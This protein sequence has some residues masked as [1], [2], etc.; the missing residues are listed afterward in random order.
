M[1]ASQIPVNFPIP[2]ANSAG[3]S[4]IRA[5]PQASQISITPGA[6]SLT[7]GFPPLNFIDPTL[8]GVPP[9]G[10]DMNGIL[11]EITAN[12]RWIQ[13]GGD[14]YYNATFAL[15]I[16]G[17]PANGLIRSADSSSWW[18][19]LADNNQTNPDAGPAVFTGSISATTLT[20][21]AITSGVLVQ[22]QI[23]SGAGVTTGTVIL[24]Q[25]TGTAGSTG[26]YTVSAS[27]T[28]TSTTITATGAANWIAN[29]INA[30]QA[31]GYINRIRNSGF[32]IAQVNGNN[33]VTVTAGDGTTLAQWQSFA[34]VQIDGFYILCTGANVTGQRV[35]G[36]AQD[37]YK[38]QITGAASVTGISFG[39]R[40][41]SDNSYDLN[42]TTCTLSVEL[43]NSLLTTVTWTA[44]YANTTDTFGYVGAYTR[45]Q[46]AT[47][48]FTVSGTAATYS[49]PIAIPAAATT[50]I[51]IVFSVGAQTS[52]TWTIGELQ[53][54]QGTVPTPFEWAKPEDQLRWCQRY[55][56]VLNSGSINSTIGPAYSN[57]TVLA[58]GIVQ[59]PTA[60]RIAP[61][62][63]VSTAASQFTFQSAGL[64]AGSAIAFI[65]AS[66]TVGEV[67]LTIA[68]AI[69]GQ[70]GRMYF[71]NASAQLYFT[72]AQL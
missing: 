15:G 18:R 54:E 67:T 48:T 66:T 2:F 58:V 65:A 4:Y 7:D 60:T 38:Y 16:G 50:G 31:G 22:G 55:L 64:F 41:T 40:I 63:I 46:I 35:A 1:L 49:T 39:Q 3:G 21:T 36:A 43:A 8:G 14:Q 45:T 19:S 42:G 6:A 51:E 69:A 44:Y 59:F 25:L 29:T 27:Q 56:P 33:A 11:N 9:F 68:A 28:V 32:P 13:A 10:Q 71:N 5:I 34:D 12:I 30:R 23:L 24:S 57:S 20:V 72:G 47:G 70:G 62:G 61:T 26:T 37:Q 17:Y 53:L 52:G